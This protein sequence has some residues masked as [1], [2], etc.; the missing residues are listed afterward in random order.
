[1]LLFAYCRGVALRDFSC[2][3]RQRINAAKT[4]ARDVVI[5]PPF[6]CRSMSFSPSL[7]R[8]IATYDQAADLGHAW[9]GT[10]RGRETWPS[11]TDCVGAACHCR[12]VAPGQHGKLII[13]SEGVRAPCTITASSLDTACKVV[14]S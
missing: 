5:D 10:Y 2:K 9:P 1:M 3:Q 7:V 11:L 6:I 8:V 4:Y 14:S 12:A 13:D